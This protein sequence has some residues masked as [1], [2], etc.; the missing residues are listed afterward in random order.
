MTIGLITI[1]FALLTTVITV[2]GI[3]KDYNSRKG[4]SD[5]QYTHLLPNTCYTHRMATMWMCGSL[6]AIST[7]AIIQEYHPEQVETVLYAMVAMCV[8]CFFGILALK[9]A[10]RG[11]WK[12]KTCGAE[13]GYPCDPSKHC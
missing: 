6:W 11:K 8:V 1:F 3:T 5:R 13:K 7:V 9:Q 10:L 2:V 12:C 4:H